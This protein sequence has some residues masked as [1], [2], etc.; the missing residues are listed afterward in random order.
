MG[1]P[2][3]LLAIDVGN[4]HTVI[5]LFEGRE[6]LAQWRLATRRDQ[7]EDEY[8]ILVRSLFDTAGVAPDEISGAAI[9]SVV[10]PVTPLMQRVCHRHLGCEVLTVGPGIKTGVA[11]RYDPPSDVGADRIVNAVAA[12]TAYGGPVVIVDFGTATTFDV[13]T[14]RGE[15]VGGV[16][17]PG[18]GI[19]ADALF[20]HA[21][22]LPR[23]EI[24]D[25]GRV[26][27]RS[28]V[29]S[30]QAGLYYG[31]AALVEGLLA[32][33]RAELGAPVQV[34]ATGGLSE[35]LA[36]A[37]PSISVVDPVLTLTGLRLIWERN[38]PESSA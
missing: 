10:P 32:R 20:Q 34:V 29:G 2:D 28:T 14:E 30:M 25:P 36:P 13:V 31:Y 26:V 4:T 37:M 9:A 27:G 16:I 7:T 5:G 21:A 18:V 6:L 22:R 12:F 33:I 38:R 15:Y 1:G 35:L 23:V 17:C 8:G 11:V 3:R 19:S 24:R